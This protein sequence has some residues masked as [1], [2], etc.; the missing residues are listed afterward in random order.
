MS[1]NRCLSPSDFEMLERGVL[2]QAAASRLRAHLDDCKDCSRV[3]QS[4]G[5]VTIAPLS[6][7]PSRADVTVER[8]ASTSP[9]AST[10][11]KSR[12]AKHLPHIDGYRILGVLG[13]GGMGIVY[14]AVQTKLNRTVALKVLPAMIGAANPSAVAR[15]RREA[16]AAARLHHTNI[17]PIYDFGESRDAYYYAMELIQGQPLSAVIGQLSGVNASS[18]SPARLASMLQTVTSQVQGEGAMLEPG[19]P[20]ESIATSSAGINASSTGRGRPYFSQVA[21]WVADAAD[22]LHYAHGQGIIHRDIKP[23]NIIL[24]IDGRIMIADFGLAKSTEEESVTMTG[25]LLGTLRY[26]SPEQAMARR[27]RVDH[28]TD[29]YSLGATMYELLTFQPAYPGMDDKEILGAIISRDPTST[30][31]ILPVVPNELDTICMKMMEKSPDKRYATARA[32]AEDLRRYLNDMP[33]VARRPS[34]FDRTMK[35]VRRHKAPVIAV[36]ALVLLSVTGAIAVT[37]QSRSYVSKVTS[38]VEAALADHARGEWD[39]SGQ[40]FE[41][42]LALDPKNIR[43][44]C[45]LAIIRKEQ[46]NSK[47][48]KDVKLLEEAMGLCNRGIAIDENYPNLWN[49]KG[50]IAKIQQKYADAAQYYSKCTELEPAVLDGWSNLGV[51]QALNNDFQSAEQSLIKGISVIAPNDVKKYKIW[52][53]LASLQ[54]FLGKDEALTNVELAV[55]RDSND[56]W[57]TLLRA[58]IH[59]ELAKHIDPKSALDDVR[60]ADHLAQQKQPLVK[61]IRALAHLRSEQL[62]DALECAQKAIDLKDTSPANSLIVAI[63]SAKKGDMTSARHAYDR[64]L[65][66]WPSKLKEPHSHVV[67]AD[68]AVLWF[69]TSDELFKLRDEAA[70][71]LNINPTNP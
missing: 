63:V 71:L 47:P 4:R 14:R 68:A 36:T 26:I 19:S 17:I 10:A 15:F 20:D 42:A 13:Q 29:I 50:V 6:R 46:Y 9:D 7:A 22:A 27:V 39:V 45:G 61:R 52:R 65:E 44:L 30:R 38:I 43:A 11:P 49:T 25:S 56:I 60:V 57:A 62:D 5:D 66:S 28:R 64:A 35:F 69:E 59:L 37:A 18:A 23:A 3:Y 41:E 1:V 21:K 48:E 2:D 32:C 67:T 51:V 70:A 31:K 16:T 55:N 8:S 40:K 24:S 33:I 54:L 58:R 53:N 12:A 34:S